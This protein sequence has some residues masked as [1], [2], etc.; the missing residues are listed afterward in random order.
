MSLIIKPEQNIFKTKFT[1]LGSFIII[2]LTVTILAL[3]ERILY[4]L[5]RLIVSSSVDYFD[6]ISVII[7]HAIVIISFLIIALVI[8]LSLGSR[9]EK[10]AIALIPYFFVSI[11]LAIQLILQ[12]SV[13]FYNHHTDFQFYSVMTILVVVST[14]AIY[15]TQKMFNPELV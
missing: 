3:S 4:D 1:T 13:Y 2:L 12:I 11:F 8:N 6:N 10:Y 7:L 9:K 14:Y 15:Y 5:A